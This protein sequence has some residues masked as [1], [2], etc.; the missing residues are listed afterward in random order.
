MSHNPFNMKQ[1][2]RNTEKVPETLPNTTASVGDT[3]PNTTA[4]CVISYLT[5]QPRVWYPT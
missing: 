2:D 1:P 3:L 5:L 4:P